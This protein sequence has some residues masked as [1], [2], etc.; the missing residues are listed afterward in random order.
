MADSRNIILQLL[1]TAKDNASAAVDG[2]KSRLGALGEQAAGLA[3]GA[4]AALGAALGAVFK[5]G[6]DAAADFEVVMARI[7]AAGVGGAAELARLADAAKKLGAESGAGPTQVAE[8]LENLVKAGLDAGEALDVLP[9]VIALAQGQMLSMADASDLVVKT[10]NQ[11]GL[12]FTDSKRVVDLFAT[13][14]NAASSSVQ[15]L[16]QGLENASVAARANGLSL[17]QTIAA[18]NTLIQNG[19]PAAEAGE[20]L[21]NMLLELGSASS[22]AYQ[23][24][25]GSSAATKDFN[26]ALQLLAGGG[27]QARDLIASFSERAQTAASILQTSR[28]F[29]EDQVKQLTAIGVSAEDAAK[30]M[31]GTFTSS[32]STLKATFGEFAQTLAEPF[33][34]KLAEGF[35]DATKWINENRQALSDWITT[36]LSPVT[37]AVD[38]FRIAIALLQGDQAKVNEIQKE[39]E[40]RTAAIGRALNGTSNEYRKA[41]DA[42]K[43]F[44]DAA[45]PIPDALRRQVDATNAAAIAARDYANMAKTVSAGSEL[46]RYYLEQSKLEAGRYREELAKLPPEQQKL[47]VAQQQGNA[48]LQATAPAARAAAAGMNEI[49]QTAPAIQKGVD[50]AGKLGAGFFEIKRAT[51]A[52]IPTQKEYTNGVNGVTQA[53]TGQTAEWYKQLPA[54]E[55]LAIAMQVYSESAGTGKDKTTQL[56]EELGRVRQAS[57]G[58]RDGMS[59]DIVTLNSLRDTSELTAQKL[60]LLEERQR[61]GEK[62]E[63]DLI[64]ARQ[65]A[66]AALA[67]YNQGLEQ[68]VT[69][70]ERAVAVAERGTQLGQQEAD[71]YVQRAQSALELARAKGD[72]NEI[73]RAET[74]L[75]DA[76][77]GKIT[78]AIAGQQQQIAAYDDLIEATRRKLA[79]DGELDA[80]D[81][82]QLATMAD[83]R[84]AMALEKQALIDTGNAAIEKAAAEKQ[85]AE[86]SKQAAEAAAAAQKEAAYQA[87]QEAVRVAEKVVYAAKNFDQL[88]EKGQA[89]LQAIG[90]SYS[91]AHGTIEQYNRAILEGTQAL[92]GAAGAEIAAAERL[93][94]LQDAAA[95]VGPA[96][97]RAQAALAD[98]AR[99]G[100]SGI[101]GITQAGEQ[102]IQTLRGIRQAALSAKEALADLADSFEEEML[103]INGNQRE[104]LERE[105]QANLERLAELRRTGGIQSEA[106]Y[107][108]A[109]RRANALHKL[110]LAQLREEEEERQRGG[111]DG[112]GSRSRSSGGISG[113]GGVSGGGSGGGGGTTNITINVDGKDLLSEEQIRTKIIPAINR[114]TRL[115]S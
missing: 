51:E 107:Q 10:V 20:A 67:R 58:W 59:L 46:Q 89:A 33:L 105:H 4:L 95:G 14:A 29:Y 27:Q 8:A 31:G 47:V 12:A 74:D 70:Q 41:A 104:L 30:I 19:V 93:E 56:A 3:K 109:V 111:S 71:L 16:R 6:L 11:F 62:V 110:K 15:D 88:S 52:A 113:G 94:R 9:Q 21:Q 54:Q 82:D 103:R 39:I 5:H 34:P 108:E 60:A 76:Q 75:L 87:E 43:T 65:A 79:A 77:M 49:G 38:G 63:H 50:A 22:D 18:L 68:Y 72:A 115:R 99:G 53:L 2:I 45:A 13:G 24:L 114:A 106:E 112:G 85:A 26:G 61:A 101:A 25:L 48:A 40:T 97:E 17:E 84:A 78:E 32:L 98:M 83:K 96:A 44:K 42:A 92:D 73:S 35:R 102:A 90:K 37:Q 57:D 86:E 66:D 36:G 28:P 81:Q 69:Q 91:A 7:K 100:G 80:S 64:L 23:Q 1:I 55:R